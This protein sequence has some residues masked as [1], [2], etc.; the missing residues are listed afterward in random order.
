MI[1]DEIIVKR[2]EQLRREKEK[3][4]PEKMKSLAD[5]ALCQRAPLSLAKALKKNTLSCICEV[6]KTSPSKGLIRPD[7]RPAEFAAEYERAG[8][9]AISCLT[10][11]YYFQ[12]SSEYL[13]EIRKKV[14]IPILRKDFIFDPYQ[15]YEAAAIGADAV[16]LIAAVLEKEDYLSLYSLAVSLGLSVLTEVHNEEE[17]R[18]VSAAEPEIVGVNNRDLKTFQVSLETV[19]RLRPYAP[20]RAVFVSE[21]GIVTNEDMKKVRSLGADAV[22]IG[23]TLMRSPDITSK[24]REL[25]QGV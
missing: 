23:E 8:A 2:K 11:E 22:L 25:R 15:I 21:S 13:R 17:M 18:K 5:I 16:L 1:L 9:E 3:V 14:K 6:K 7:F 19:A 4:S 12:G 10:E 24:L 20:Q